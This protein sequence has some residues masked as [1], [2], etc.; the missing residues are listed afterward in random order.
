MKR[1]NMGGLDV[2]IAGEGSGPVVVLLHGF[3]APGDDLVGL[4]G[5]L[6]VTSDTRFVFPAAPLVLPQEYMG[7]RAWWWIDMMERA[8]R[9]ARGERQDITYVPEGLDEA[10]AKVDAMLDEVENALAP[11]AGKIVLGGFS[12]GAM[13]SLDV[14]LRSR[15]ALAGV[16]LL[17]GTHVA[18]S[19][20]AP[21]FVARNTLPIFMSHGEQDEILPYGIS[22]ALK[23]TLTTNGFNVDWHPFRGGH[24]IPPQV[25][26]ALNTFLKTNV[27]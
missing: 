11:P 16:V 1:A 9:I 6:S 22:E 27:A 18:A 21:N 25:V 20:W 24:G 19:E 8:R 7:G 2:V 12:Q 13:L 23:E 15:R 5:A 4:G 3:G 17:S 26:S 10:R 14:A